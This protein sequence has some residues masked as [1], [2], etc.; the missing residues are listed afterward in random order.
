MDIS[1]G[2]G[3][4]WYLG[5]SPAQRPFCDKP[6]GSSRRSFCISPS[7][8]WAAITSNRTISKRNEQF[9]H[10]IHSDFLQ[11]TLS[12]QKL[13]LS[14]CPTKKRFQKK[15]K[16][17]RSHGKKKRTRFWLRLFKKKFKEIWPNTSTDSYHCRGRNMNTGDGSGSNVVGEMTQ[18]DPIF[19]CSR[20]IVRQ[21]NLQSWLDVLKSWIKYQNLPLKT[22]LSLLACSWLV[23]FT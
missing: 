5:Y 8:A 13:C 16:I 7:K 19:Q 18:H 17:K 4:K 1:S 9:P 11:L 14:T 23:K 12:S 3:E 6:P 10:R 15:Q 20:Q 21:L 2:T 22:G